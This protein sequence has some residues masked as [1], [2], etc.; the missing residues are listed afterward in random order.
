MEEKLVYVISGNHSLTA[1]S[2]YWKGS[3]QHQGSLGE[4]CQIIVILDMEKLDAL[5]CDILRAK[6]ILIKNNARTKD[7][8]CLL[9][10]CKLF[11][12]DSGCN[13]HLEVNCWQGYM[14][15]SIHHSSWMAKVICV[16]PRMPSTS[17]TNSH[18]FWDA[19]GS[20]CGT[21][22][23]WPPPVLA[24]WQNVRGR[25][26]S[27]SW[28][29]RRPTM[30]TLRIS[31]LTLVAVP[32]LWKAMACMQLNGKDKATPTLTCF[33]YTF[34]VWLVVCLIVHIAI[35]Q[36]ER[37]FLV[38]FLGNGFISPMAYLFA[39]GL[40]YTGHLLLS[41][42]LI[43]FSLAYGQLGYTRHTQRSSFTPLGSFLS[44]LHTLCPPLQLV[45]WPGFY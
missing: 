3:F 10:F 20:W 16:P 26:W 7:P 45:H 28:P 35:K 17:I 30:P 27:W 37:N 18:S 24:C 14:R 21:T 42:H 32:M 25:P 15:A 29:R 43:N 33:F 36:C 5:E 39:T 1:C 44:F 23:A 40:A 19:C 38:L 22:S 4:S 11:T 6:K 31:P 2:M 41:L 8:I 12:E 13:C 9:L 34:V